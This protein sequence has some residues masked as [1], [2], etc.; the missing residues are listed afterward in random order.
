MNAITLLQDTPRHKL[1]LDD[2]RQMME[3]GVLDRTCKYELIDGAVFDVPAENP[4]HIDAKSEIIAHLVRSLPA[5]Y[6]VAA[7]STLRLSPSDAPSPDAY[8]FP[9]RIETADLRPGQ[10][11]LVIEVAD[12]T[13]G[14]DLGVKADLY[15]RHGVQ[16]YWVVDIARRVIL[17]H[18]ERAGE[19]WAAPREIG[20]DETARCASI[21]ELTLRLAD[22][23][24]V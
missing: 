12:T 3:S 6:F 16:E 15:A 23:K 24:R 13:L 7:D 19:R 22:L 9:A 5:E 17:V 4:P 10:V 18:R 21:R 14:D 2:V 1:T 8:V 11:N 20:A